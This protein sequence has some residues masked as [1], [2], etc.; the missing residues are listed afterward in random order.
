MK[1]ILLTI[2]LICSFNT[3]A[4]N[5]I[6]YTTTTN[7]KISFNIS[8]NLIFI[9]TQAELKNSP[10]EKIVNKGEN[11][12]IIEVNENEYNKEFETLKRKYSNIEPVLIY[13]DGINQICFD[14]LILKV[15]SN[16]DIKEILNGMD[17]SLKT[18]DFEKNQFLVTI[19]NSDTFKI[20]DFINK[21][22][23][24]KRIEFIEPNFLKLNVLNTN[25]PL[26]SS[27]WALNNNGYLGGVFDA[28]MDVDDAWTLS[29]GYGIKVAILDVGVDLLH[30]DLQQNLLPGY[31]AINSVS[32]GGYVGASYHGTACAGIV[33]AVGNNGIGTVGVA[34]NSKIIPI[35]VGS[36]NSITISAAANGINWAWQNGADILSNSWGGGSA[37]A[38]VDSA[39]NNAVTYGRSGKGSVVLF[40]AGNNNSSVAWPAL[41]PQVIAVGASS[42]CDQRKSPTSCDGET[43]WGS[44]FGANLDVVAPGVKIFTTDATGNGGYEI[45]NYA[46]N[47]NGTSSACPNTAGVVALILSV[48]PSLTGIQVRQV[49]ETNTDK[50]TSYNYTAGVPGQPNGSW[51]SEMGY[52]RVNAF[53]AV[54]SVVPFINGPN[55]ICT[56]PLTY[57]LI[58]TNLFATWSLVGNIVFATPPSGYSVS[59]KSTSNL[60]SSGTIRATLQN[61]QIIEKSITVGGPDLTNIDLSLFGVFGWYYSGVVNNTTASV[62]SVPSATSYRWQIDLDTEFTPSSTGITP[63]YAKFTTNGSTV[64]VSNIGGILNATPA[65]CSTS[66]PNVNIYFGNYSASYIVKCFAVNECGETPYFIKYVGLSKSS[67]CNTINLLS[68]FTV[69]PNPVED[70]TITVNLAPGQIPCDPPLILNG[71]SATFTSDS[72]KDVKIFDML[73]NLKFSNSYNEEDTF[74]IKGINLKSGYYILKITFPNGHSEKETI[75]IE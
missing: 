28:D 54:K 8:K 74:T 40:S 31:D 2:L 17:Y 46:P 50:V 61:G 53:K 30:P 32:G 59:V 38:S 33:G 57:T 70:G 10:E 12:V 35:R 23:N 4:Q 13:Q 7:E 39:I 62:T 6:S 73:G 41:N 69:S 51:N 16:S 49:L 66:T 21:I 5:K 18:N 29:T 36:G 67:P 15:K 52:G 71:T 55:Q 48:N 22:T 1:K 20:F 43:F 60:S 11:F 9:Q 42:Q 45:G 3:N 72:A 14:E 63:T 64:T 27:Q 58:N 75:I 19:N 68:Q 47:F 37:S 65:I 34:Y 56:N 44:N 26:F 25:D 24:D